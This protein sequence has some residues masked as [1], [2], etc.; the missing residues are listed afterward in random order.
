[1][2]NKP[3][4]PDPRLVSAQK[5]LH[6]IL[7][8][9]EKDLLAADLIQHEIQALTQSDDDADDWAQ[10]ILT[11]GIITSMVNDTCSARVEL[12]YEI[13]HRIFNLPNHAEERDKVEEKTTPVLH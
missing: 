9:L 13:C 10:R 8:K 3:K 12:M 5:A 2:T 6:D 1:M 11:T 4:Q 7:D